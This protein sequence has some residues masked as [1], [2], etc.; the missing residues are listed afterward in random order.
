ML[1]VFRRYLTTNPSEADYRRRANMFEM[2]RDK[3]RLIVNADTGKEFGRR[4]PLINP[5]IENL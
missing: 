4:S 1:A 3:I 5:D 2:L